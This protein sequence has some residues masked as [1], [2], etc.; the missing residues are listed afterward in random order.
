MRRHRS[1]GSSGQGLG[2]GRAPGQVQDDLV[3]GGRRRPMSWT[4]I[5]ASCRVRATSARAE[6]RSVTG[7]TRPW[8]TTSIPSPLMARLR[9][10]G[11]SSMTLRPL[12]RAVRCCCRSGVKARSPHNACMRAPR[13]RRPMRRSPGPVPPG[14]DLEVIVSRVTYVGSGEHKTFP[15]FAGPPHPRADASKC[16]PRL[17][18]QDEL[19]CWLQQAIR[20]GRTGGQWDG[21]FPRYIWHRAEGVPYEARLVNRK[22][23]QYKG[24][25]LAQDE[26]P[27]TLDEQPW[28]E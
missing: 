19:T 28:V 15:S 26:W 8:A 5:P 1:G 6:A 11:V 2:R 23:G 10:A 3:E 13:R 20:E 25:P 24:Y 4:P 12:D 21:D 7:G 27:E 16:D 22:L 17:A 14:I 9:P 18:D